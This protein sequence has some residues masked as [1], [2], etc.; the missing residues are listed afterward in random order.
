MRTERN[1]IKMRLRDQPTEVGAR[2]ARGR[3]R[4]K[5][6]K[7]SAEATNIIPW[8]S[9]RITT[10]RSRWT[11]RLPLHSLPPPTY[12]RSSLFSHTKLTLINSVSITIVLYHQPYRSLTSSSF[13]IHHHCHF[14]QSH[15]VAV[16]SFFIIDV[17]IVRDSEGRTD[18]FLFPESSPR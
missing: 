12:N 5:N 4:E 7:P 16:F 2:M 14:H 17:V 9:A 13:F 15:A 18:S 1:G 8:A 10:G 6:K 11:A 3:N